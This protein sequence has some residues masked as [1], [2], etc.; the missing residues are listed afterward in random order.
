MKQETTWKAWIVGLCAGADLCFLLPRLPLR[1]IEAL[2]YFWTGLGALLDA[3]LITLCWLLLYLFWERRLAGGVRDALSFWTAVGAALLRL[4]ICALP[5]NEWLRGG[6]SRLWSALRLLPLCVL[7]AA[8]TAAW[9]STRSR[10]LPRRNLWLL[11][12]AGLVLRLLGA[13]LDTVVS[14]LLLRLPLLAVQAAAC[15]L[16]LRRAKPA[17]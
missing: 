3:A 11:L 15:R 14:P 12:A 2:P 6:A 17:P 1:R 9:R 13:A 5:G 8:V 10:D 4:L 16:L 7:A